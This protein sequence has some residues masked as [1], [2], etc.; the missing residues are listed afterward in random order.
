[1]RFFLCAFGRVNSWN[2]FTERQFC[3]KKFWK[4]NSKVNCARL[5][6]TVPWKQERELDSEINFDKMDNEVI[7]IEKLSEV[8]QFSTWKFQIELGLEAA[9]VME[10]V[11]GTSVEPT[12]ATALTAWK[13]KDARA[14]RIIGQ[15]VASN[16][17]KHIQSCVTAKAMWDK[18]CSVFE[19]KN[20]TC[21]AMLN[22]KFVTIGK[23]SDED[24]VSYVARVEDLVQHL[25]ELG[26]PIAEKMVI[27]RIIMG[28]PREY[29]S[30]GS[31]WESTG[32]AEKT[33]NTLR[34]RLVIEEN[35]L[36]MS[37]EITSE[38]LLA[39]RGARDRDQR[40]EMAKADRNRTRRN[41]F[42]DATNV[43]S[44]GISEMNAGKEDQRR[45]LRRTRRTR[46]VRHLCVLREVRVRTAGF[47]I[48]VQAII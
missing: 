32:A 44:V 47:L 6:E 24:M 12:E 7:K 38:A 29:G 19:Q 16:I 45:L 28:L 42:I 41:A 14:K 2:N 26:Q 27:T 31:A 3:E 36:K 48:L 4:V 20:E 25:S 21:I 11:N 39:R 23:E 17:V 18:L 34:N 13:R 22:E 40:R 8:G 46:K 5:E 37:G 43:E 1:M 33:L 15:T 30:F 9:E 10:V 35:R